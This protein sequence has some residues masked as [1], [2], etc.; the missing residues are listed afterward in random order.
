MILECA[1]MS[2]RGPV[3]ENNEDNYFADGHIASGSASRSGY[4]LSSICRP[5]ISHDIAVFDGMGGEAYGEVASYTAARVL[6]EFYAHKIGGN[7]EKYTEIANDAIVK[8]TAELGVERIGTTAVLI[9]ISGENASI[10]NIGDSR[11]YLMRYGRLTQVSFDHR[12]FDKNVGANMLTQH[13][14]ID[15]DEFVVEP[16]ILRSIKLEQGMILLLCTDGVSD[17]IP[18]TEIQRLLDD[19]STMPAQHIANLLI[20]EAIARKTT[21]NTTVAVIKIS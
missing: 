17:A 13:L 11:A 15:P 16:Y 3:R 20:R 5:E 4:R 18:N 7:F 10:C 8:I 1:V 9:H 14:G 19:N 12:V 2:D 21:D 6:A